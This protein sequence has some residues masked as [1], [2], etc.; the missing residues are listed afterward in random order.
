MHKKQQI[1]TPR[2]NKF[3]RYSYF[4][5]KILEQVIDDENNDKDRQKPKI[6]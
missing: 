6:Q 4:I 1:M 3:V 2:D 5:N